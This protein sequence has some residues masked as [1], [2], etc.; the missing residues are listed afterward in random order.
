VKFGGAHWLV[1]AASRRWL[2]VR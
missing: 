2:H 1:L